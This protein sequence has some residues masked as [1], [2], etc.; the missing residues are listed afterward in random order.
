M[1]GST[2]NIKEVANISSGLK[3]NSIP[4]APKIIPKGTTGINKGSISIIPLKIFNFHSLRFLIS[5][6]NNMINMNRFFTPNFPQ[7]HVDEHDGNEQIRE[8]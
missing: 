2:K 6:T 1:R 5:R 4:I 3:F 7:L 8:E